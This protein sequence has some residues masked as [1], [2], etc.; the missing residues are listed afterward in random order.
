MAYDKVV[1]S[2][3]LDEGLTNIA[4]K[5]REKSGT[6][7]TL[8]FPQGF[9]LAIDNVG[10]DKATKKYSVDISSVV[11]SIGNTTSGMA[12]MYGS[13]YTNVFGTLGTWYTRGEVSVSMPTDASATVKKYNVRNIDSNEI[14]YITGYNSSTYILTYTI[15]DLSRL[16]SAAKTYVEDQNSAYI[17]G[18]YE[19]TV[20]SGNP[21]IYYYGV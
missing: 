1:D 17:A 11:K 18:T 21:C 9:V 19:F 5:I 16:D 4:N 8:S 15:Y 6:T 3:S 2:T 20:E 10:G 14:W 13:Y 12:E 7:G